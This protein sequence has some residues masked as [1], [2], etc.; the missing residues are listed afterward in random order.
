M[1]MFQKYIKPDKKKGGQGSFKK[2]IEME[3]K[4][5]GILAPKQRRAKKRDK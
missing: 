1:A 3:F 4:R 5:M 2:E